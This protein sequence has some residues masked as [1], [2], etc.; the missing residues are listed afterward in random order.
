MTWRQPTNELISF[1]GTLGGNERRFAVAFFR[2]EY[3]DGRQPRASDFGINQKEARR[4]R[5]EILTMF[6]D[7]ALT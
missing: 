7:M 1:Y 5:R 3:Q 6:G 4:I 2:A